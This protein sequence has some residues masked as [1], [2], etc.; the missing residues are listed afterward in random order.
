[1]SGLLII[2]V[3]VIY[4]GVSIDLFLKGQFAMALTFGAYSVSNIGLYCSVQ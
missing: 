1:M 2:F 3:A 4:F